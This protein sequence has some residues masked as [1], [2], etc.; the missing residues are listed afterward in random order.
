V[1]GTVIGKQSTR[2]RRFVLAK[3]DNGFTL[4]LNAQTLSVR[5]PETSRTSVSEYAAATSTTPR[6]SLVLGLERV[7]CLPQCG[8]VGDQSFGRGQSWAL[9]RTHSARKLRWSLNF[10]CV[11]GDDAT[12]RLVVLGAGEADP[13]FD[14]ATVISGTSSSVPRAGG[15]PAWSSP[16]AAWPPFLSF[17]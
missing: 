9:R 6:S 12:Y 15:E 11:D 14:C 13:G 5:L 7:P 1:N 10:I 16:P 8:I 3:M 2:N 17:T 4:K